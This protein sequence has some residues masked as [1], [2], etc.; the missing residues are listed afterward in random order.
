MD[1]HAAKTVAKGSQRV[2][3]LQDAAIDEYI[4]TMLLAPMHGIDLAGVIIVNVDCLAEPAMQAASKLQQFLQ[5]KDIPVAVGLASARCQ[6]HTPHVFL[7]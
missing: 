2:V 5:R 4:C 3:S 1:L 6:S 7:P